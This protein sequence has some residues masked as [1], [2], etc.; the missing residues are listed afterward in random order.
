MTYENF[1]ELLSG[2][3]P[4]GE[5]SCTA[6]CPSHPD[7]INSLSVKSNPD[8]K[9]IIFCFGGCSTP[10]ILSSLGLS[11]S[12]IMGP[13]RDTSPPP[14]KAKAPKPPKET[15]PTVTYPPAWNWEAE[16]L[17]ESTF[18][19]VDESGTLLYQ[20]LRSKR[21]PDGG[22]M[23]SQRRPKPGGGWLWKLDDCRRVL[24]NLP[25]VIEALEQK[26]GLFLVEGEKCADAINALGLYATSI[27]GGAS[28]KW[29]D[30][31]TE[32]LKQARRVLILPDND[33]P[34]HQHA[35]RVLRLIPESRVVE[36]PGLGPK[37]DVC[38]WI[39]AGGTRDALV[40]LA[41]QA[42][43]APVTTPTIT[44]TDTPFTCLGYNSGKYYVLCHKSGQI[45][46][47][48]SSALARKTTFFELCDSLNWW[49]E[50][51]KEGSNLWVMAAAFIIA[52]C[53]EAGM[54][55]EEDH[56]REL[57]VWWDAG[58]CV[59]HAGGYL[60]VNGVK[61]DIRDLQTKY[62]YTRCPTIKLL[63]VAPLATSESD[64]LSRLCRELCWKSPMNGTLF[65]GWLVA[66]VIC[67]A[68]DWRPHIWITGPRGCGK[69]WIINEL[70]GPLLGPVGMFCQSVSTEAGIR[71][72]LKLDAKP[73]IFDEAE[74]KNI[75]SQ[76][77]MDRILELARS[78]S[79]INVASVKK[80][81]ADGEGQ[82]YAIKSA[83]CWL[84]IGTSI[85]C[86]ADD[87]RI[88]ILELLSPPKGDEGN[89]QF[90]RLK[91]KTI[92]LLTPEFCSAFI[93]R[94]CAMAGNVR[95]NA[96]IYAQALVRQGH[97]RR[98]G[99][100]LGTL[101]AGF[102]ALRYEDIAT[103]EQADINI[104]NLKDLIQRI[105][106]QQESISDEAR[107]LAH[108]LQQR[109]RM[110]IP[111]DPYN[112]NRMDQI[113]KE[114]LI[115]ELVEGARTYRKDIPYIT[116]RA[117]LQRYGLKWVTDGLLVANRHVGLLKL[118]LGTPFAVNWAITLRRLP[119]T[120]SMPKIPFHRSHSRATFIPWATVFEDSDDP[121]G[122][123]YEKTR[124]LEFKSPPESPLEYQA[125]APF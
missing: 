93:L 95:A 34:G 91:E 115:A 52:R 15:K 112:E 104:F 33:G 92:N 65:A 28:G 121:E 1:C 63:E 76:G 123:E 97:H 98:T 24:Y 79:S 32:T 49:E 109:V 70:L 68:L 114:F 120:K 5:T 12:D 25:R 56:R 41:K 82:T 125:E 2:V 48:T 107:C 55:C 45:A 58:R 10:N 29:H 122:E 14:K 124:A 54:Y 17:I 110:Q 43:K 111:I 78:A 7:R 75:R 3:K 83:F 88:T 37:H 19:Y 119:G 101:M 47:L 71:Q 4:S 42:D 44:L 90:A 99:D 96:E 80:G 94:C 106:S 36:L 100:Q 9:L 72:E 40:A 38:D 39:A 50:A 64:K 46:T 26:R 13:K 81:T 57:G 86:A 21:T 118:F 53:H 84:S 87:S 22:K 23:F 62:V 103:P 69:T 30:E 89:E 6:R 102:H 61:C 60:L 108:L 67:G 8:G 11:F 85:D 27:C 66:A 77:N 35:A 18:D 31:Y 20:V 105:A 116:A 113:T 51:F 74:A 59:L 16:G 117:E 73:V